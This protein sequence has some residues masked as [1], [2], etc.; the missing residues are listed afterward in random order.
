MHTAVV[1]VI[2]IDA[3]YRL[4]L[5]RAEAK[6]KTPHVNNFRPA[7]SST[8]KLKRAFF[9]CSLIVL[10]CFLSDKQLKIDCHSIGFILPFG[11]L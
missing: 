4:N 5:F 2:E 1:M 10:D 6:K 11:E 7:Q 8:L 9:L 3:N